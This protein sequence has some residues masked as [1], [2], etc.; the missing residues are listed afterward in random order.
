MDVFLTDVLATYGA[1][2]GGVVLGLSILTVWVV[3]HRQA[4]PVDTVSVFFGLA[5]YNNGK[6]VSPSPKASPLAGEE[7]VLESLGLRFLSKL[8]AS[9]LLHR[10]LA[11]PK[12][13]H[14]SILTYTNEV[15][16]GAITK[17]RVRGQ[18]T[19]EILKRSPL[20]DLRE[21][22][23]CNL[24]RLAKRSHFRPWRKSR[25]S[26]EASEENSG[27]IPIRRNGVPTCSTGSRR[28]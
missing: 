8:E 6:E 26:I 10:R 23:L 20:A 2:A 11:D 4:N 3:A 21:E 27:A 22:Q 14:I 19:L 13:R 12:I 25:K 15:E 18:K 28:W 5:S 16:A 24:T 9:E 7:K 1:A 17:Y